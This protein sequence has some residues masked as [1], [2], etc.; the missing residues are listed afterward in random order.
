MRG[1][2]QFAWNKRKGQR[3]FFEVVE[4]IRCMTTKITIYT[5]Y[6]IVVYDFMAISPEELQFKTRLDIKWNNYIA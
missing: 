1:R 2:C 6:R 4:T 3:G 5:P